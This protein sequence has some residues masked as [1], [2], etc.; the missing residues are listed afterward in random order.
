MPGRTG[1]GRHGRW[2]S[3]VTSW[4]TALAL[5]AAPEALA[6]CDAAG[7]QARATPLAARRH[8]A[9]NGN[10]PGSGGYPPGRLGFTIADVST[11]QQLDQL[12]AGVE[13]LVFVGSCRGADGEFVSR[14]G[15]F[16]GQP[17][18]FGFYLMDE[19]DPQ[20]CPASQLAQESAW[21]H[22]HAPGAVT[23]IVEQNLS[24]SKTPTYRGGYNAANTGVDL[25]GLDPYPCRSEL[26]G[27][28]GTMVGRF[29]AAAEAFGISRSTIVPVFQ[30]FGGG[31]WVDDGGGSYLL[32]DPSQA[33]ELLAAWD[34]AVPHPAFDF[35]YSWGSQRGDIALETAPTSLQQVFV[36]H[37]RELTG[38]LP[39]AAP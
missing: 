32:P 7:D 14:V 6:S 2:T 19:P 35:V 10:V 13:A 20:S 28:D 24:S 29:V 8:Y 26:S 33:R 18:V 34:R 36:G 9:A 16:V 11:R 30:A 5:V 22:Q 37:N 12:P 23:F 21:I 1:R 3:K 25:F 4:I 27:C 39:P 17:Q 31:Q 38:P 15:E